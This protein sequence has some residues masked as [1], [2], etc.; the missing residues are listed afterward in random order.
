[1]KEVRLGCPQGCDRAL[2]FGPAAGV[3]TVRASGRSR[4]TTPDG[5]SVLTAPAISEPVQLGYLST[6]DAG[7]GAHSR[8]VVKISALAQEKL[9]LG[10]DK[11]VVLDL[12]QP[13]HGNSADRS[14][15]LNQDR[16]RTPVCSKHTDV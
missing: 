7:Q 14:D 2:R 11:V 6:S 10:D 1:M 8:S 12:R 4:T 15:V 16:E 9:E 5:Y 3:D 13:G